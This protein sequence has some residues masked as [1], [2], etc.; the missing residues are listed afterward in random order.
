M[1]A[2][3]AVPAE[4]DTLVKW[5]LRWRVRAGTRHDHVI[6]HLPKCFREPSRCFEAACGLGKV[7]LVPVAV[8]LERRPRDGS[9]L[10]RGEG[11]LRAARSFSSHSSIIPPWSP[12]R[13]IGVMVSLM[14]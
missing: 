12:R 1:G 13:Y 9:P 10:V 14:S 7:G 5:L 8:T 2:E 6:H 3:V 4:H 11:L